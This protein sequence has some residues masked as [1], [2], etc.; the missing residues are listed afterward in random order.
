[1]G[2][3]LGPK[4]LRTPPKGWLP[5]RAF[6]VRHS[7]YEHS[8][9]PEGGERVIETSSGLTVTWR[10]EIAGREPY[11]VSEQRSGP[12][13]LQHGLLGGGKRWY[14]VR[15]R[16]AYGLMADVGVPCVVDPRDPAKLWIDWDA[17]YE[18]HLPAWEREARVRR[19]VARQ[20]GVL[21]HAIDRVLNPFAGR[22]RDG[23]QELVERRIPR[24]GRPAHEIR[25]T[26][27][28]EQAAIAFGPAPEGE[29]AEQR[30]RIA[31]L[32]RIQRIGRRVPAHVVGREETD[33][34]LANVPLILIAFELS[35]DG[36]RGSRR[37]VFE[38]VYGPRQ[39]NRYKVGRRVDVWVDPDDPA[40]ICPG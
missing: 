25:L 10:V 32:E 37:V 11:E 19:A 12:T 35:D 18:E 21:D 5:A 40:A 31:E 34:R 3:Q 2:F 14:R 20:E 6:P 8:Q 22:L 29:L 39:A 17:A 1:M 16:P 26:S 28:I 15:A 4:L 13:W 38:H 7:A 36:E 27:E 23:E 24:R 30:R 9:G 33:G